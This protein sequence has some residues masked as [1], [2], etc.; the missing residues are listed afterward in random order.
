M[1][2]VIIFAAIAASLVAVAEAKAQETLKFGASVP[3]SGSGA[4]WGKANELLCKEA[5]REIKESG[6]IKVKGKSYNVECI[7]Y[8]NKYTASEGTK[9]A[10]TLL[11]KD[12][13]RYMCSTGSAPTLAAQSLTER[14]GVLLFSQNWTKTGK[15]P[16]F[17]LTF[18]E[19]VTPFEVG[20]AIIEYIGKVH[21]GAKSVAMLNVNDASG[22]EAESVLRPMWEKAG[23]K[24]LTS[25]FYERGTTEFQP[26]A[27]RLAALKADIVELASPPPADVGQIFKE[28][29]N[30]DFKGVKVATS[31][32]AAESIV[33]TGGAAA[34]GVLMGAAISI[35]SP[36]ATERMRRLNALAKPVTGESIGIASMNCY[37]AV[38]IFRAGAEKAQSLEPKE[39]AAA[40]P[41]TTFQSFYG[42]G[43]GFG[44]K[45]IYGSNMQPKYPVFITEI[46]NGKLVERTKIT[47]NY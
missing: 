41:T 5:A 30:L 34:E 3:L 42:D 31:G 46:V 12:G 23:F 8:D 29:A 25:D 35:D 32:T 40:I 44:G 10:Q 7:A 15:G 1:K 36:D 45:A 27:L 20:P 33:G 18:S 47:P 6:G 14:Q 13:V 9:V 16:D 24:V 11:N 17:P 39:I 2:P 21:P 19:V 37:D 22:H 26:I 38:N 43:I 4:A 28:L